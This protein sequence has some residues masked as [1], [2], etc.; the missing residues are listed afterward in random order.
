MRYPFIIVAPL[1]LFLPLTASAQL[2]ETGM[3]L[4]DNY[5]TAK[6]DTLPYSYQSFMNQ[7]GLKKIAGLANSDDMTLNVYQLNDHYCVEVPVK[8]LDKDILAL[9]MTYRGGDYVSPSSGVF[10]FSRGANKHS[11]YL[12]YNRSLDVQ[13]D[14]ADAKAENAA[15][16]R[17]LDASNMTPIDMSFT[18]LSMGKDNK[19]FIVDIT[20]SVNSSRGLFDVSKNTS[21]NHPDMLRSQLMSISPIEGGVVFDLYRSQSDMVNNTMDTQIEMATTSSLKFILQLL[22]DRKERLKLYNPFYG[23]DTFSRQEY[24]TKSYVSRR[25]QYVS[26]WDFT[27]GPI[28][29]YVN[30]ITPKPFQQSIRKAFEEWVPAL[31]SVGIKQPFIFTSDASDAVMSYHHIYVDWYHA[32]DPTCS[33]VKDDRSGEILAA[34]ISI[35]DMGIDEQLLSYYVTSRNID[36]RI[37]RDMEDIGVRQDMIQALVAGEVGKVLGLKQNDNGY[38]QFSPSQL[39]SK[40]WLLANGTTSSVTGKM[41]VN[42]LVQPGDGV[43]SSCLFPK[44]SLYDRDAI[45]Y[46]YG[47][48]VAAPS[49][50]AGFFFQYDTKDY[51]TSWKNPKGYLSN[52]LVEAARLGIEQLK[53]LYPAIS[54]DMQSLPKD[55]SSFD[56]QH[57]VILRTLSQY[58][59]LLTN[60][61]S[62]IGRKF[63][64]PVQKGVNVTPHEYPSKSE[65]QRALAFIDKEILHGVPTWAEDIRLKQ[66]VGGDVDGMMRA[67]AVAMYKALLDDSKINNL[68]SAEEELGSNAFTAQ[69]LFTFIDRN[70]M[71]DYSSSVA[72]PKYVRLIQANVLPDLADKVFQ[73]DV[74]TALSNEGAVM[75]HGWFV[76]LAKKVKKLAASHPDQATRDNYQFIMMRLNRNYFEKQHQ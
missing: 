34:R 71:C 16:L 54:S 41:T 44:V 55:Q 12:T 14:S 18:V 75:L 33:K 27:Q 15:M 68:I 53:R 17:A 61:S 13:A 25:R 35:S 3:Q 66:I 64:Y 60:V 24:D 58:Q 11:L 46:L 67:V 76:N 40:S 7:P 31:N 26:R 50:D 8:A 48:S 1:V 29:V 36:R 22:P 38:Y 10:R 20:A 37:A 6:S 57:E 63:T 4:G 56:N 21:L 49:K 45:H 62:L 73:A 74:S 72:V 39:R 59:T 43:P 19:S 51:R 28:K 23:F 32:G 5:K 2:R 9:A 30:P 70:L 65:Q 69:D 47:K 52:D 42:Y